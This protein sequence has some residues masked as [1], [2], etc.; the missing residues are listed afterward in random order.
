MHCAAIKLLD[1]LTFYKWKDDDPQFEFNC[2]SCVKEIS[3]PLSNKICFV[4][5]SIQ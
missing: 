3:C 5:L 1:E 2:L 4:C